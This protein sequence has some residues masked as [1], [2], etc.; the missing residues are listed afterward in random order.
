MKRRAL[1]AKNISVII[2]IR[3]F[4]C[5]KLTRSTK[6]IAENNVYDFYAQLTHEHVLVDGKMLTK[7]ERS[8]QGCHRVEF[9]SSHSSYLT[10]KA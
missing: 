9:S 7:D 4:S 10:N 8:F 5:R 3:E 2:Y 6:P 1:K